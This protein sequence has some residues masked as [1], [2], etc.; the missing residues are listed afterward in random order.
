MR[1]EGCG[2]RRR[3]RAG[4]VG[5]ASHSTAAGVSAH[6]LPTHAEIHRAASRRDGATR[7]APR[8]ARRGARVGG[9]VPQN[10]AAVFA[11]L[12]GHVVRRRRRYFG[13][14][15]V[16]GERGDGEDDAGHASV[17]N[18]GTVPGADA[19]RC[20]GRERRRAPAAAQ[21]ESEESES[22]VVR[23]R[24]DGPSG[25]GRRRRRNRKKRPSTGRALGWHLAVRGRGLHGPRVH[26]E[27]HRGRS[28]FVVRAVRRRRHARGLR[29]SPGEP[30]GGDVFGRL[31][32]KTR[33]GHH[34][35]PHGRES[36]TKQ[37]APRRVRGD[38]ASRAVRPVQTNESHAIF[39][40]GAGGA[41]RGGRARERHR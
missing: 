20:G 16:R 32:S 29:E 1:R 17:S 31:V 6:A 24:R 3:V 40:G 34:R 26:L 36:E 11:R 39:P 12:G 25:S 23:R 7:R 33:H 21:K 35:A 14:E 4:A 30:R 18:R 38:H 9:E 8:G 22:E 10:D 2:R 27:S 19:A 28:A 5:R 13:A 41:P 37:H 15:R